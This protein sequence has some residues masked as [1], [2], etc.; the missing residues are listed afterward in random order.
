MEIVVCDRDCL[1]GT[2]HFHSD[3]PLH[4]LVDDW[5]APLP[6]DPENWI[7]VKRIKTPAISRRPLPLPQNEFDPRDRVFAF[8][9]NGIITERDFYPV[10]LGLPI[11]SVLDEMVAEGWISLGYDA[12]GL[13]FI[14]R[15]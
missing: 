14:I 5:F 7:E 9:R 4:E 1:D 11:Q 15:R 2:A 13:S 10:F 3:L 8:L 6:S 12:H